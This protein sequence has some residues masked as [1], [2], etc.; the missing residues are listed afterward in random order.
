MAISNILSIEI[1]LNNAIEATIVEDYVF[2]T[3]AT[4]PVGQWELFIEKGEAWVFT[5]RGNFV[6]N[7]NDAMLFV[8]EDGEIKIKRLYV[9]SI[10]KFK[11]TELV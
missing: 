6:L 5:D 2:E 3:P 11:A 7:A 9:K 10:V 8:P 4:L 1:N